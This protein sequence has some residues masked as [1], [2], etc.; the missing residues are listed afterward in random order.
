MDGYQI[1]AILC[2]L[3]GAS[4]GSDVRPTALNLALK[5][6]S[7]LQRFA[8]NLNALIILAS[9][10][11]PG[12]LTRKAIAAEAGMANGD[13]SS[14]SLR[15]YAMSRRLPVE[16][17]RN[18]TALLRRKIRGYLCIALAAAA[19]SNQSLGFFIIVLIQ[20]TTVAERLS[21][22]DLDVILHFPESG[23]AR[24]FDGQCGS[25]AYCVEL[26]KRRGDL[27]LDNLLHRLNIIK[28]DWRSRV[29]P[30]NGES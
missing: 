3:A 26:L 4:G 20:G 13:A 11:T 25:R 18:R 6:L 15:N 9:L 8:E 28:P 23:V 30:P 27:E 29:R 14:K 2:L 24:I 21:S 22:T 16:V 10:L 1:P 7:D 12:G 19:L 17:R 5:R